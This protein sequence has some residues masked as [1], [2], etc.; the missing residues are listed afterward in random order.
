[1]KTF[2]ARKSEMTAY[3]EQTGLEYA[4]TKQ[5]CNH[6]HYPRPAIF[7]IKHDRIIERLVKCKP[8]ADQAAGKDMNNE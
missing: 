3:A 5:K 1:M 4:R 7:I 6:C 2:F 8:C